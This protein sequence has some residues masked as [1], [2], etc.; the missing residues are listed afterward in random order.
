MP[1]PRIT[2]LAGPGEASTIL[3]N[4]LAPLGEVT[5]L[6]EAPLSRAQLLRGRLRRLGAIDVLGQVAFMALAL[7]LLRREARPRL[8]E[9]RAEHGLETRAPEVPINHI[10]SLNGPDAP[11]RLAESRPDLV[12]VHGTRILR[13]PLLEAVPAP[14][15][16]LH[17]GITPDYRGV[18][19]G[20]W[21]LLEG[22]KEA[23][24]VTAHLVDRGVDTGRIIS[25]ATISP[26]RGDNFVTYP[27]LQLAA[28]LPL[29]EAAIEAV[30]R[31]RLTTGAPGGEGRQH[32]HP[33]LWRYL[34]G[35]ARGVR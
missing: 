19:G 24:G 30:G 5:V 11:A 4:R 31:G 16:N 29:L 14:M 8:A 17:A 32:Y 13:A 21:A 15:I 26:G 20:Y 33:T 6:M 2:I 9:I 1:R 35:R 23:C 7:P 10:E 28:G 12:I 3:I 18:H 22:R 34:R 27:L 25:Q